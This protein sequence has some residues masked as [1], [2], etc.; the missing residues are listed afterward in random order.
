MRKNGYYLGMGLI[1]LVFFC[2]AA[3]CPAGSADDIKERM[4][5]RLPVILELKSAGLV[6][7]NNRGYLQFVGSQEKSADVVAAENQDRKK[8]YTAI[9]KQQ[10]VS[11]EVVE[12]HRAA[13]IAQKARQGEWLQDANGKWYQK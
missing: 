8:V 12:K 10:G 13:Q 1:L 9:A 3:D 11:M 4:K 5:A 7:E 2:L 6:G